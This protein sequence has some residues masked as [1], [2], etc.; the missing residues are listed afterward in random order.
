MSKDLNN[1][2]YIYTY[3]YIYTK[4]FIEKIK[5]EL[6]KFLYHRQKNTQNVIELY[7]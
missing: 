2:K 6:L 5:I 1:C 3:I 7:Q 4:T